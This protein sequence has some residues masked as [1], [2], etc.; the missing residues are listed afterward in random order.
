MYSSSLLAHLSKSFAPHPENIATE[1]LGHILMNSPAA[2]DAM[3]SMFTTMGIS[4]RL[5]FRTQQAEGED[6]A[7][8][9]LTGR[10][11]EGRNVILIEPK[12]WAGLTDNQPETYIGMLADELLCENPNP[13]P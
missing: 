9:D 13:A 4:A 1:A 10:D 7:R 12:F 3:A 6:Q 11:V 2:T 8:P 5:T